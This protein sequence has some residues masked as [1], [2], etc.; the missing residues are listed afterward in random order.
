MS[1]AGCSQIAWSFVAASILAVAAAACGDDLASQVGIGS[2]GGPSSAGGMGGRTI[3]GTGGHAG[4]SATGTGGW[5]G[6]G[7]IGGSGP[8]L[9]PGPCAD[10][11]SDDQVATYEL[12]IA[13]SEW[14]ALMSDFHSMQQN[15]A[16]HDDYHPY[17]YLAEFKYGN[18][19]IHNALIRL[20]GWSS[21]WQSEMDNPP[22]L[23]FVISFNDVDSHGRFHGLRKVELDMPRID[24]SYL[25]QRIAL[26][27]LRALGVPAQCANSARVFIN[28][29]F[30]GLYTNLERPDQTFLT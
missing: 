1:R 20:K 11:F 19:V 15:V 12:Q 14:D 7:P 23:Q 22:K 2:Q 28:G 29:S 18:E 17:H 13:Q 10:V 4:G 9:M 24:P 26:A 30:Y 5:T 16:A 8:P 21:W 6:G 25:R 27:Y 3:S